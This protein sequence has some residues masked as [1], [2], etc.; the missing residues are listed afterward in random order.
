MMNILPSIEK[1][2]MEKIQ[3]QFMNT[4]DVP[5]VV[6]ASRFITNTS[7]LLS[8]TTATIMAPT[9]TTSPKKFLNTKNSIKKVDIFNNRD[10]TCSRIE[11]QVIDDQSMREGT[12]V[13][14]VFPGKTCLNYPV[15]KSEHMYIFHNAFGE[16]CQKEIADFNESLG[17]NDKRF[18]I[19]KFQ[20]VLSAFCTRLNNI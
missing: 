6:T 16:W 4:T 20:L 9:T 12:L 17:R 1:Q 8:S 3:S 18:L 5:R 10:N 15:Y 7:G 11:L 13:Y 2:R 14:D 19:N